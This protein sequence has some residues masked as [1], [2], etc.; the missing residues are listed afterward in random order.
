MPH[1]FA[2]RRNAFDIRNKRRSLN[3]FRSHN[4]L[5]HNHCTIHKI[6]ETG[7]I[8][9]ELSSESPLFPFCSQIAKND[10]YPESICTTCLADL[11]VAFRFRTNCESSASILMS[12]VET[13][14]IESP[15]V[16]VPPPIAKVHSKRDKRA[17]AIKQLKQELPWPPMDDDVAVDDF[18]FND[19]VEDE[20]KDSEIVYM[21]E[22]Q[23]QLSHNDIAEFL[24]FVP[25]QGENRE[26]VW[27]E[28]FKTER[29]GVEFQVM[30]VKP[31]VAADAKSATAADDE[32]AQK[33]AGNKRGPY[34][35]GPKTMKMC[36]LCGNTYRNQSLLD[37]HMRRHRNERPF[38]CQ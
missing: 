32:S 28:V 20:H 17:P 23:R 34:K 22:E 25:E 1:M 5:L 15:V 26:G 12:M 2:T 4:A 36:Q 14:D 35:K 7:K 33:P 6:A 8:T 21:E 37:G 10:H 24:E 27:S 38:E 3:D 11:Q 9:N 19:D 13:N 18:D 29:E 31:I 30:H 16:V